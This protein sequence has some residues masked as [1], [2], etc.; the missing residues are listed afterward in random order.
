MRFGSKSVN[1]CR[2]RPSILV[3]HLSA[4]VMACTL[5][6]CTG[7]PPSRVR[8][9]KS[10]RE[11]KV[12]SVMPIVFSSGERTLMLKY[13]TDLDFSDKAKLHEEVL[14]IWSE[15]VSDAERAGVQSAIISA[16]TVP[17]GGIIKKGQMFNF[18][19]KKTPSGQWQES[20]GKK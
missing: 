16:N 4:L 19:F 17:Q 5:V 2:I 8:R 14:D 7:G 18:V 1:H 9:L 6:G 12:L 20:E 11:V 15:F 10:G 13:E 3:A